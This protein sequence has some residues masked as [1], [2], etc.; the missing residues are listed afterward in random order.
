MTRKQAETLLAAVILARSTSYLFTKIGLQSIGT[1][2]LLA[3]RSLFAFVLLSLMFR[4]R[5]RGIGIKTVLRGAALGAAFFL[6]MT[7]ELNGLKSTD[8]STVSFLENTAIIFVPLFEALLM[9]KLPKGISILSALA[10]ILGVG[11]L[12][13]KNGTISFTTGEIYCVAAAM[14]YAA[15]IILTD[16]LSHK[17]DGFIIGLLQVGF[18][19]LFALIA[20][21]VWETP[22]FPQG[23]TEWGVIL[24]LAIV[25]SGFGF[26]FQPVAQSKTTAERAGLFCAL[27]PAFASLMGVVFLSEPV[28]AQGLIG[29]ALILF[30]LLIPH[31]FGKKDKTAVI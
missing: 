7:A 24:V 28:T 6:V 19:G 25:C 17:D 5:L 15:S 4:K 20:S 23:G 16:R 18:M 2:N 1:F 27:N 31:L 3:L 10:A 26:T 8:T 30:S 21:F 12:T 11:F 9:R 14:L 22:R 13:L 29:S